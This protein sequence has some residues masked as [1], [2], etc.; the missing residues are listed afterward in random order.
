MRDNGRAALIV[1]AVF[2]FV[3]WNVVF[4]RQVYVASMQFTQAQIERYQAGQPVSSIESAFRPQVRQAA[5]R[6]SAWAGAV[7]A[8]GFF[9][10]MW[11]RKHES[12]NARKPRNGI[13]ESTKGETR[14]PRNHE[15]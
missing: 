14:V 9:L 7:L 13:H 8:A 5:W 12:A 6:A 10:T 15:Q 2:A 3:A 4:D 1:W 11:A